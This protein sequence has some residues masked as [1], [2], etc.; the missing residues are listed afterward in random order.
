MHI[1]VRMCGE[2]Q[3]GPE[4]ICHIVEHFQMYNLSQTAELKYLQHPLLHIPA[5]ALALS[6][7]DAGIHDLATITAIANADV[8]EY[9]RVTSYNMHN[10]KVLRQ[11]LLA[12]RR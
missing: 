6:K 8:I 12:G 11:L 4:S 9:E 1:N 7:F 5:I 10:G 2:I 3:H